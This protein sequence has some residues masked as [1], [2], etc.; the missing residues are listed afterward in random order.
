MN[1]SKLQAHEY[2][3]LFPLATSNELDEMAQD[4][5][6]RGL[7]NPIVMLDGLI[8]DGRNRYEACRLSDVTPSFTQYSGTD[9]LGDVLSWNLVRRQLSASQRAMVAANM[10]NMVVGDNRGAHRPKEGCANLQPLL[11]PSVSQ[12]EA[13]E[14]LNVSPRLVADAKAIQREAPELAAKVEANEITVNAAKRIIREK[15]EPKESP[16]AQE[17]KKYLEKEAPSITAQVIADKAIFFLTQIRPRMSG[18]E[19]ALKS[20]IKWCQKRIKEV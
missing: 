3:K 12:L 20:V 1:E 10:A 19:E 6:K 4:I 7:L 14:R 15:D 16:Q 5:K 9:P 17:E 13:A 8:L 2:A 18:K 11:S